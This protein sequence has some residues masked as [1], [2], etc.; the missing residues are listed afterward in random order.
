M[1]ERCHSQ[2]KENG[3]IFIWLYSKEGNRLYLI[4]FKPLRVIT[5][6][7]PDEFLLRIVDFLHGICKFYIFLCTYINLPLKLYL[8]NVYSKVSQNQQKVIIFDQLNPNYAKYYSRKEA[9]GLLKRTG[10]RNIRIENR[11]GYSWSIVGTK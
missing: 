7:L 8:E 1:I 3:K 11:Y 9:I 5:K 2:L 6:N 4:L 10:F